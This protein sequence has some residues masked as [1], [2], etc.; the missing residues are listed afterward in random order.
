MKKRKIIEAVEDKRSLSFPVMDKQNPYSPTNGLCPWCGTGKVNEPHSM[1][2]LNGG[3]LTM[4]PDRTCGEMDDKLDGFLS[5]LWHGAHDG[6]TGD[7][8][9]M[10]GVVRIAD[11]CRG[12]QFEMYFCS[13]NCLRGFLNHCVDK[14]EEV[15]SGR[16][17]GEGA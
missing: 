6:G 11:N 2:I 9:N 14:L 15:R 10:G 7:Y 12:G 13:T 3:A 16:P 8:P 4:S 1:A 5:L 17:E